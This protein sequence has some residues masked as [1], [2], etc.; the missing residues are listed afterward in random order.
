MLDKTCDISFHKKLA[1]YVRY[2]VDGEAS[3]AFLCNKQITDCT[4]NGIEAALIHVLTQKG[5]RASFKNVTVQ[6]F[7]SQCS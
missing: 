4:A 7:L 5:I 3:V 1:I 6:F 2:L